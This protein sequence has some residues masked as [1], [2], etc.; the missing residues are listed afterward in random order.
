MCGCCR[1][2]ELRRTNDYI[3][4]PRISYFF[5]ITRCPFFI[6]RPAYTL[7][8]SLCWFAS[9]K[10]WTGNRMLYF[11]CMSN[12]AGLFAAVIS[13]CTRDLSSTERKATS[14]VY[15]VAGNSFKWDIV[16]LQNSLSRCKLFLLNCGL[17]KHHNYG[18]LGVKSYRFFIFLNLE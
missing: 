17:H 6:S 5:W 8:M 16:I 18:T 15:N 9:T 14:C 3:S 7:G 11:M 12:E 10:S 4:V 13:I 1:W 2:I